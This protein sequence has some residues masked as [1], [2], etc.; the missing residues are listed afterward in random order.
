METDESG[1]QHLRGLLSAAR[2]RR[3]PA[4]LNTQGK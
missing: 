4:K 2:V 3:L 1:Q